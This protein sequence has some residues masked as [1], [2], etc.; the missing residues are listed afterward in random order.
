MMRKEFDKDPDPSGVTAHVSE[1]DSCHHKDPG[2]ISD[3]M[4]QQTLAQKV[5]KG[6]LMWAVWLQPELYGMLPVEGGQFTGLQRSAARWPDSLKQAAAMC[7]SLTLVNKRQ[8][9]G[10]LADKQAFKAVEARFLVSLC[11]AAKWLER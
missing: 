10:D 1:G 6:K 4:W 8:V 3:C 5:R 9:V 11:T 7:T 2:Y